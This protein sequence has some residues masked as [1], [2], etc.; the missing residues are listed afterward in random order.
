MESA[1]EN[2]EK[3][4][5]GN[6][7]SL[8]LSS[9]SNHWQQRWTEFKES[10]FIGI[11]FAAIDVSADSGN[12]FD[13][14]SGQIETGSSWLSLLSMMGILGAFAMLVLMNNTFARLAGIKNK[15][16]KNLILSVLICLCLYMCGEGYIWSAGGFIFFITWLVFGGIEGYWLL[17]KELQNESKFV[18]QR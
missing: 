10:P 6:L 2:L 7:I 3:K 4:N 1:I 18:E 16:I 15:D 11:G 12:T 17:E 5:H 8:D 14:N 9:R 13:S